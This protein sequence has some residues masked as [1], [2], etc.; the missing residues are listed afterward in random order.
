M[1]KRQI[2]YFSPE[3]AGLLTEE[4]EEALDANA[5][6]CVDTTPANLPYLGLLSEL[7]PDAK[8]VLCQRDSRDTCVSIYEQ[9]LSSAH[10]YANSLT[11]LGRYYTANFRLSQ[12]WRGLLGDRL[13]MVQYERMTA[14]PAREIEQLLYAC[15]LPLEPQC[16][17]PH[18]YERAVIT[19]SA[20]QV[21]QPVNRRSVGRWKHYENHLGPLLEHLP[22]ASFYEP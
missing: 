17:E 3:I 20:T 18:L 8:F 2:E 15:G 16:L 14:N 12:H 5:P 19:P 4:L 10:A 13:H 9:P 7:L 21:R 6:V 22:S 11:D 1:Y